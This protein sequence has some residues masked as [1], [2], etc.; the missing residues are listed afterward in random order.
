MATQTGLIAN[1]ATTPIRNKSKSGTE[2]PRLDERHLSP[3]G[4]PS[5]P[6]GRCGSNSGT[7]LMSIP[8][9]GT[10]IKIIVSVNAS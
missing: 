9:S 7:R 2:K 5:R 6:S 10:Q 1:N 8:K 3:R 4:T